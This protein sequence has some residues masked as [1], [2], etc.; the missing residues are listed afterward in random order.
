MFIIVVKT[1]F[2]T[3]K[4]GSVEKQ[5][6]GVGDCFVQTWKNEGF[7]AFFKVKNISNVFKF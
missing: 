3:L 6:K 1:R 7:R 4:K 5:F 2:Q